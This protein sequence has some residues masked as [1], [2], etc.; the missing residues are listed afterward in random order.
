MYLKKKIGQSKFK[1]NIENYPLPAI[2]DSI[3][4]TCIL[5]AE[6][7]N[8]TGSL[9][10]KNGE[11]AGAELN[12]VFRLN[13]AKNILNWSKGSF[14]YQKWTNQFEIESK[15]ISALIYFIEISN[16]NSEL[17]FKLN[18]ET[19]KIT[20]SYGVIVNIDPNPEDL[21]L[22][23]SDILTK[24]KGKITV[25][26][27]GEQ[28]GDLKVFYSEILNS[29]KKAVIK[30]LKKPIKPKI[31][32]A[33][34]ET[35][36]KTDIKQTFELIK[37]DLG[38]AFFAGSVYSAKLGK[39]IYSF[40][41]ETNQSVL[42]AK[43]HKS[44]NSNLSSTGFQKINEFYLLDLEDNYL[45]FIL[46]FKEHHFGLAFVKSKVKLGYLFNIIKPILVNDYNNALN[47]I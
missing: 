30:S 1:G 40:N 38:D 45:L 29:Q 16:F 44:I 27:K 14:Y 34:P 15:Y 12:N 4:F 6:K 47:K 5:S 43:L 19:V 21:N 35:L 31:K 36:N 33:L 9:F 20:C 41:S 26:K 10:F 42:L 7:G 11:L 23:F 2:A 37:T 24:I 3:T 17:I 46:T 18:N 8:D 13:Q 32:K 39:P 25:I 28:V 22:F